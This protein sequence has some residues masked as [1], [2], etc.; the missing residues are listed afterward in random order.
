MNAERPR[1]TLY[2]DELS[3]TEVLDFFR[4]NQFVIL[5][6]SMAGL[7]LAWSSTF[8]IHP[9]YQA[10]ALIEMARVNSVSNTESSHFDT[11]VEDANLLVARL[12]V[13]STF[14]AATVRLC[15]LENEHEPQKKLAD[16]VKVSVVPKVSTAVNLSVTGLTPDGAKQCVEALFEIIASYHAALIDSYTNEIRK[17]QAELLNDLDQYEKLLTELKNSDMESVAYLATR[18]KRLFLME[19]IATLNRG[20]LYLEPRLV[21]PIYAPPDP[22][23]PR[24]SLVS[25]A[26]FGSGL[27]FGLVFALA[28]TTLGNSRKQSNPATS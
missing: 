6:F 18:E 24:K 17:R 8:L 25:A 12:Q 10:S 11:T 19:Q 20:L 9:R 5:G 23:F 16:L 13:P 15:G 22:V 27:M 3:L 4:R 26:G 14:T 21:S 1:N 7:L 2:E 28:R